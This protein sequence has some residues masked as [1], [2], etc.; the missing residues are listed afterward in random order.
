MIVKDLKGDKPI[1]AERIE[2]ALNRLAE[3]IVQLGDEGRKCLPIYKRPRE[4]TR[5]C[6]CSRGRCGC[7]LRSR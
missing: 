4:R 5:Q 1:T 3:I 7:G 2:R 6:A